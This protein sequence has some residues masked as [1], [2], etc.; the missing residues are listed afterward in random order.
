MDA[1]GRSPMCRDSQLWSFVLKKCHLFVVCIHPVTNDKWLIHLMENG[2][3]RCSHLLSSGQIV[4][5]L[6]FVIVAFYTLP[7]IVV[8]LLFLGIPGTT[9]IL[10]TQQAPST[11]VSLHIWLVKFKT[12]SFQRLPLGPPESQRRY[13]KNTLLIQCKIYL[14]QIYH[15]ISP[16]F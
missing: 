9:C 16:F 6:P 11:G 7:V 12:V 13:Q 2:L 5:R 8:V 1:V 4:Y 3:L 10:S 14:I 15:H